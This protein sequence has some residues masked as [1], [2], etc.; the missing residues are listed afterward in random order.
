M[1]YQQLYTPVLIELP[2]IVPTFPINPEDQS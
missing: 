2:Q 1:L